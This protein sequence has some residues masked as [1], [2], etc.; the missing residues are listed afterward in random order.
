MTDMIDQLCFGKAMRLMAADVAA[1]HRQSGGDVDSDTFVWAA[2][3]P[4]WEVFAGTA[5]STRA[6]VEAVCSRYGVD[7]V[8]RGWTSPRTH[9]KAVPF[10]P[11]PELVHGVAVQHPQLATVLRQAGWF[12]G[13]QRRPIDVD[14]QPFVVDRD[15]TGAALGVSTSTPSRVDPE[16]PDT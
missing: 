12:S 7:P 10:R 1:W 9:R 14:Q 15:D 2:L 11:T 3:A 8:K 13:K 6:E 5:T 16:D 4:P